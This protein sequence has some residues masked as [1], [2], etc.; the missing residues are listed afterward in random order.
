MKNI[1]KEE[2]Q[3]SS[4][5]SMDIE[6]SLEYETNEGKVREKVTV[7]YSAN[8]GNA[9]D[10][11]VNTIKNSET[12]HKVVTTTKSATIK[13]AKITTMLVIIGFVLFI[14]AIMAGI[15]Q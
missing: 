5:N 4:F 9:I 6:K 15:I 2:E 10:N 13:T 12:V 1:T 3:K 14:L 8:K 11:A 7:N